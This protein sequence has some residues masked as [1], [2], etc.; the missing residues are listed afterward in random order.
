[1]PASLVLADC[2]ANF[3]AAAMLAGGISLSINPHVC[4]EPCQIDITIRSEAPVEGEPICIA[5]AAED[6]YRES[7]WPSRGEHVQQTRIKNIPAGLYQVV[8]Q[9]GK[10]PQVK[11]Q[12]TVT[13]AR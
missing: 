13:S 5:L 6:W 9:V 12:L 4:Q 1:M 3:L 11:T 7:C 8:V 10:H 2:Y